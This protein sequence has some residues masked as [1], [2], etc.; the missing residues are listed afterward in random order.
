MKLFTIWIQIFKT[1]RAG[2]KDLP[3]GKGSVPVGLS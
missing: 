1:P 3:W 2:L